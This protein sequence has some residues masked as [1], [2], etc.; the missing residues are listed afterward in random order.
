MTT[1]NG[2]GVPLFG[3]SDIVGNQTVTGTMGITGAVT[4]VGATAITGATT[5][6]GYLK[7]Q[8]AA[9]AIIT[10]KPTTGIVKGDL[11][12]LFHNTNPKIGICSS[13]A[14]K[15]IKMIRLKTATFG[16]LTA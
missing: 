15:K 2:L 14:T 16:R 10:T 12:V 4:I 5:V 13:T 8:S 6:K 9:G 1:Y 7:L 3:D 11:M